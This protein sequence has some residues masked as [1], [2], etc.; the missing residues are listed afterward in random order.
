MCHILHDCPRDVPAHMPPTDISSVC[1]VEHKFTYSHTSPQWQPFALLR[2]TD[3]SGT[4]HQRP[5]CFYRSMPGHIR[6]Y[7]HR[8]IADVSYRRFPTSQGSYVDAPTSPRSSDD[9]RSRGQPRNQ[10]RRSRSPSPYL[11]RHRS[12]APLLQGLTIFHQTRRCSLCR[13]RR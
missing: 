13:H 4:P 12:A 3:A 10:S 9:R 7:C 5:V 8:R 11:R 1:P 6:P 2:R